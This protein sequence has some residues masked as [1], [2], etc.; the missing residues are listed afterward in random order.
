MKNRVS[1]ATRNPPCTRRPFP[2]VSPYL[3]VPV[4]RLRCESEPVEPEPD[5]TG[6]GKVHGFS[7]PDQ[8]VATWRKTCKNNSLLRAF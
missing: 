3:G 2:Y 4:K 8:S 6:G 5:H 7:I 1:H